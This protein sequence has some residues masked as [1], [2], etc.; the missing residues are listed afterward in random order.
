MGVGLKSALAEM[1]SRKNTLEQVL[2]LG[3]VRLPDQPS[4]PVLVLGAWEGT[5]TPKDPSLRSPG[6]RH[7]LARY[8][9]GCEMQVG[10]CWQQLPKIKIA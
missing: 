8:Q 9:A 2:G 6:Q 1:A 10:A 3:G 5:G 4:A 7:Q